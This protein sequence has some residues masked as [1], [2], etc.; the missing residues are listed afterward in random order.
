M[1]FPDATVRDLSFMVISLPPFLFMMKAVL[2]RPTTGPLKRRRGCGTCPNPLISCV[3]GRGFESL[4][5]GSLCN[6]HF[7]LRCSPLTVKVLSM[8]KNF[9]EVSR[10]TY[11]SQHGN[12]NVHAYQARQFPYQEQINIDYILCDVKDPSIYYIINRVL[13]D[14]NLC[15]FLYHYSAG[16]YL[17]FVT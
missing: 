5:F 7:S 16:N 1:L 6:G 13:T 4:T 2:Y 15:Y 12:L 14:N 11:F 9:S 10:R 8:I 17:P 3:A